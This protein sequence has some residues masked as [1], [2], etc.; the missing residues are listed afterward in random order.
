M[1][2]IKSENLIHLRVGYERALESKKD[3]LM[4]EVSLLEIAKR[5]KNYHAL[6]KK[7]LDLKTKLHRK[8]KEIDTS[9]KK[10]QNILPKVVMPKILKKEP[11]VEEI[12]IPEKKAL[13]EKIVKKKKEEKRED[14]SLESQL[15]AIKEKLKRFE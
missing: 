15:K 13:K 9:I 10:L 1:A 4:S 5:M 14:D 11:E 8:T 12:S 6:R 7:E 2:K 3:I